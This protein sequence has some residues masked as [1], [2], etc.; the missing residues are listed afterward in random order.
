LFVPEKAKNIMSVSLLR[1]NGEDIGLFYLIRKGWGDTR[2]CVRRSDDEGETWSEPKYCTPTKGYWE[3]C[4]D[5]AI[6]LSNGRIIIPTAYFGIKK[7]YDVCSFRGTAVFLISDDDGYTW[8][9]SKEVCQMPVPRSKTG[10]QEPGIVELSNSV[11]WAW[12]R[13]DM[14]FQ[15]E[16]FSHDKG[17]TWTQPQPSIFTSSDSPMSVKRNE[18]AIFAALNPMPS[19]FGYNTPR[20]PFI[21]AYSR[22]GTK[23]NEYWHLED[24]G[25][26]AG[27]CYTAIH[28]TEEGFLLAYTVGELKKGHYLLEKLRIRKIGGNE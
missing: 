24:Y 10:L 7:K 2:P 13:T 26:M 1:M 20:N 3:V 18:R 25:N 28:F 6:K 22:N 16:S 21:M 23:W 17:D 15:Y 14:G 19:H 11:L 12:F 5:R 9:E 8:R 27:Y 4:N